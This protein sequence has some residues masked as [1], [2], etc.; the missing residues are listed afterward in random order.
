MPK[1]FDYPILEFDP[2]YEAILEPNKIVTEPV[3]APENCVICF[4]HEVLEKVIE[5]YSPKVV[6]SLHWEDGYHTLYEIEHKGKRLAFF[7]PGI[8]SALA[9]ALFEEIIACGCKNFIACGG[10]GVLDKDLSVGH[11][12]V[13]DSAVRDEGT[14]Y[15]YLPPSREVQ[16]DPDVAELICQELTKADVPFIKGKAWTTDAPYRETRQRMLTRRAEGCKMVEMESAAFIAI[17]QFRNVKFGQIL[18]G[19]DDLSGTEW[20]HRGWT[21]RADIRESL[22]WTS[23]DICVQL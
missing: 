23:A 1:N 22:F 2:T 14:S 5:E 4:F 13:V 7:H 19:G 10:A 20:D 18:Y 3:D 17:S 12:L 8:G 16:A 15:Q 21:S 11:L 9:G 6:K